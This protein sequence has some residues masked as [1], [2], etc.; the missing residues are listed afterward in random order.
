L[1]L[2]IAG[3]EAVFGVE[4]LGHRNRFQQ[5]RFTRAIFADE[6][7]DSWMQREVRELLDRGDRIGINLERINP[8]PP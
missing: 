8:I 7:R 2:N 3:R 6:E 4:P 5:R 1:V